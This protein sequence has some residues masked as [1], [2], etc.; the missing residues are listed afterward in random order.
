[1]KKVIVITGGSRGIGKALVCKYLEENYIVVTT[2]NSNYKI[3]ENEFK[4]EKNN[5]Y[6]EKTGKKAG[7]IKNKIY[8][9]ENDVSSQKEVM[10]MALDIK[11]KLGKVDILINNAGISYF[12]LLCDTKYEDYK[13]IMDTNIGGVYN[14]CYAFYNIFVNQKYG[15]ILNISSIFG[16]NGASCEVIYSASKG[17]VNSFTKALSK[18]LG[19]SNISVNAVS[20]GFVETEMNDRLTDDEKREFLTSLSIEKIISPK[21][22]AEFIFFLTKQDNFLTGQILGFDGGYCG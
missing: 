22:V 13:K 1:M 6:T 21:E 5:N 12:N 11:S 14:T 18:E 17:A 3:F 7:Y 8:Y 4:G 9:Y 20:L 2:G 16:T 10:E 19:T 15:K